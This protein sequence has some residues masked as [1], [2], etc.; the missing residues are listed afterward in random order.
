MSKGIGGHHSH[1][2]GKDE[3]L[4]PPEMLARLGHFDLD[5]CA[6]VLSRRPWSTADRHFT[7]EDNGLSLGWHGRVWCNPPYG[8]AA[9]QWLA[10]LS[11]HGNGIALIFARTETRMFFEHVWNKVAR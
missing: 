6:P 9:A 4:T 2:A 8:A 7:I 10:R 11:D 3:W 1:A 5:L